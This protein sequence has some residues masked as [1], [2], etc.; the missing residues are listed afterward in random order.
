MF[1]KYIHNIISVLVLRQQLISGI[2]LLLLRLLLNNST[3]SVV[4]QR[5]QH[6]TYHFLFI[7]LPE[8]KVNC[9]FY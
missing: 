5:D 7:F 2:L 9:Y 6:T 3:T 1:Q 8:K 4:N